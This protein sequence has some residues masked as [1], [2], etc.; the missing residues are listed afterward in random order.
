MVFKSIE[1]FESYVLAKCGNAVASAEQKVHSV[2]DSFLSTY[3]GEFAPDEY[4]RTNQLMHS[5]VRTGVKSTGNGFEAEVYFDVG[6]LNY[7]QGLV[8]LQS[9]RMGYATW[10][11]GKVLDTAMHGSH[12]GYVGGTPIW[13]AS[14]TQ[15]GNILELLK[16]ELIKQGIPIK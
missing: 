10:D 1:E 4:I 5:L 9:G 8:P 12:G 14:M 2:I 15:L 6:K 7:K 11:G 16:Q 13:D 3:Y